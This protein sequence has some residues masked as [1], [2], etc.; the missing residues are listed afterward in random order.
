MPNVRLLNVLL[1]CVLLAASCVVAA[2]PQP[3]VAR[4]YRADMRSP[5]D[6]FHD[7]ISGRGARLDLLA[8]TMGG[9]CEETTSARASAWVSTSRSQHEAY[10]FAMTELN[11]QVAA[12]NSSATVWVYEIR[13]DATYYVVEGVVLQAIDI[14][15]R[16]VDGYRL[17]D[18]ITLRR[19]M[20]SGAMGTEEEVVVRHVDPRNIVR[21]TPYYYVNGQLAPESALENLHYFPELSVAAWSHGNLSALI[22]PESIRLDYDRDAS[23]CSMSCD[24]SDS[25]SSRGIAIAQGQPAFCKA[26]RKQQLTRQLLQIILD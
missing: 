12:G 15:E 23:S 17:L 19:M 3:P 22:P 16:G 8:H 24:G 10:Q 4:V 21:A 5:A 18:A 26:A 11:R 6:L 14:S 1:S 20:Y 7:G 9:S 13:P 2:Q 25:S